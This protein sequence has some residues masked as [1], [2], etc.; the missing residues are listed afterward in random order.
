MF[1]FFQFV[2]QL[3]SLLFK[4]KEQA[5]PAPEESPVLEPETKSEIELELADANDQ[6]KSNKME[7]IFADK[8]ATNRTQFIEK[9]DYICDKLGID[10]NWL[11]Y[12]MWFESGLNPRAQ[13]TISGATGLIQ[14]MPATAAYL[15]TTTADLMQMSNVE[16]LD[17]VY[18][19]LRPYR[20]DMESL[21]DVYLAVFFPAAIG[22]SSDYVFQTSKLSASKIASQNPVFDLNR[23]GML[24]K[25]EVEGKILSGV[26]YNYQS[27]ME[28]K[29]C[30]E[31]HW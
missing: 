22:K 20:G 31:H 27:V 30:Y 13:N 11:M 14:F 4:K 15:G 3:V 10:P 28:K 12:V 7:L 1:L 2:K 17:F 8:I 19:Y 26:P 29:S 25:G 23:D 21:V 6:P 5:D 9:L 18:E 24:T 16:Q